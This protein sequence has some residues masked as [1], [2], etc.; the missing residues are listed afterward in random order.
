MIPEKLA[1][2]RGCC[3]VARRSG[4]IASWIVPG[5]VLVLQPKCPMC[6]ATYVAVWTGVG[7]S[8]SAATHLRLSLLILS[9]GSILFLVAKSTRRLFTNLASTKK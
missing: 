7:L 3:K 1:T 4:E 2:A 6:L 8:F 5:A 9:V